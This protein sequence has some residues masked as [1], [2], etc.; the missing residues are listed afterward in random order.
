MGYGTERKTAK[1]NVQHCWAILFTLK[2][3]TKEKETK[4][5]VRGGCFDWSVLCDLQDNYSITPAPTAT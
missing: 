1:V 3:C 4:L 2:D 5:C